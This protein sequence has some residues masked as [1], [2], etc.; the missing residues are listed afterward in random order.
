M[1]RRILDKISTRRKIILR[2][3]SSF[4]SL[5][6]VSGLIP[7]IRSRPLPSPKFLVYYSIVILWLRI[8]ISGGLL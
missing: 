6:V 3:F 2:F 4:Q 7:Q 1:S 5:E 8:G